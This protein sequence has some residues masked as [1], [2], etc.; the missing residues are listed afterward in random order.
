ID[1]STSADIAW[2]INSLLEDM[3]GAK[4]MG[5]RGRIRVEKHFTWNN[6]AAR[7]I[8]IY[9]DVIKRARN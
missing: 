7:T 4:E 8:E 6:I 1:G 2:G 9:E 5:K 3:E